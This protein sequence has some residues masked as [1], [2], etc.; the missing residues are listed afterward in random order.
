M[1]NSFSRF[2]SDEDL[3][4]VRE[5]FLEALAEVESDADTLADPPQ[6]QPGA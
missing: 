2:L 1:P 5:Q 3:A 6:G 4:K